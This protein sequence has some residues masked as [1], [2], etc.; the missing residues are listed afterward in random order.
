MII[1]NL[2]IIYLYN[3]Y[4]IYR[5]DYEERLIEDGFD[6]PIQY[7]K[8]IGNFFFSQRPEVNV[9]KS[10]VN[11]K[12][13]IEYDQNQLTNIIVSGT[14]SIANNYYFIGIII[15]LSKYLLYRYLKNGCMKLL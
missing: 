5:S 4:F 2:F 9:P 6:L 10:L 12:T 8:D 3:Q 11:S 7:F 13:H 15:M 1:F 14:V